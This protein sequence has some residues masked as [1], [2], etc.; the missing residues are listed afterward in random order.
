MKKTFIALITLVAI[1]TFAKSIYIV[2][3]GDLRKCDAYWTVVTTVNNE[4]VKAIPELHMSSNTSSAS[5]KIDKDTEYLIGGEKLPIDKDKKIVQPTDIV[6]PIAGV[7]T[8]K[9]YDRNL[10][11]T[12]IEFVGENG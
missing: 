3:G 9:L 1:T 4:S 7:H 12:Q 10:E 11:V 6:F 2:S 8:L 5:I